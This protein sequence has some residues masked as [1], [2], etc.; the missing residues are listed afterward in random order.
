MVT[1]NCEY[2]G[3]EITA[4]SPSLLRRF[5]S[6]KCSN[7]WKWV[8][9]RERA[10]TITV[11]CEFCG[12]PITLEAHDWRLKEGR[13]KHFFCS[14]DCRIAF[15]RSSRTPNVCR[16]CGKEFMHKYHS[17]L[18]CSNLCKI[19]S[20]RYKAYLR[21][22][23]SN[24]TKEQFLSIY[25]SGEAFSFAGRELDYYK[26][27]SQENKERLYKKRKEVLE[28]DPIA[29]YSL[30]IKKQIQAVYARRQKSIGLKLQR[31]LGC[32][33]I[34]FCAYI[35]SLLTDGMTPE[36]YG[37]WQLDHI[38]PLSSAKSLEDV[39]RLCRYTNYQPLWRKD[40]REK[41]N[42]EV[43]KPTEPV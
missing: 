35:D 10:E 11:K 21:F 3:K 28:K 5:C 15:Q 40:N 12:E 1:G 39:E 13:V 33:A 42:R 26:E 32:Q 4:K 23:D 16:W 34:E 37:E 18:Y 24:V 17:T 25:D 19:T 27:Y 31:I 41:A 38:I 8:A 29:A 2:C 6:Y 20:Q 22:H 30:K 43:K 14:V 9:V 36:N 7:A